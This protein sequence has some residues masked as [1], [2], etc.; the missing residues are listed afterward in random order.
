MVKRVLLSVAALSVAAVFLLF[1][2]GPASAHVDGGC[3]GSGDFEKGAFTGNAAEEGTINVP[4]ADTVHWQ[5]ALPGALPA[6]TPYSG[7]IEVELPP[8]FSPLKIDSW[9]G[10][11]DSTGNSGV[12]KYDLPSAVPR[13]V[14][15]E[16]KGSHTQGAF[17]CSGQVKLVVQGGKFG[18]VTIASLVGTALTGALFVFAGRPKVG[19]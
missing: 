12:K 18:P 2:A 16:V 8:P 1:D 13:G 10:T 11:S 4:L 3:T 9:S 7:K 6:E 14:E 19:V 5:G 15:F 17:N